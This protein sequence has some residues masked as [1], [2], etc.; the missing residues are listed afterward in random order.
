ME[1]TSWLCF[2]IS[3]TAQS[4]LSHGNAVGTKSSRSYSAELKFIAF[5]T[6]LL[7]CSSTTDSVNNKAF[8]PVSNVKKMCQCLL[9]ISY[10]II[11]HADLHDNELVGYC[12]SVTCTNVL[13]VKS[14]SRV[15]DFHGLQLNQESDVC[16]CQRTAF[17]SSLLAV[18]PC[19]AQSF[20]HFS[21]ETSVAKV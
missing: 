16:S 7:S 6:Q 12:I 11:I 18:H 3:G 2:R 1:G 13:S 4:A 17:Q 20:M 15:K 19:K 5:P 8:L 9:I 10:F 14:C 21:A